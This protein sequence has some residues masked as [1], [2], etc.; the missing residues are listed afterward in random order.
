MPADERRHTPAAGSD[1]EES[2]YFDF[3]AVDGSAAGFAR[4]GL[5][6]A[7]GRAWWWTAVTGRDRPLVLVR[8]HDVDPPR[9]GSLEIRASGLWAE[10]VCETPLDHWSLGLE[11]LAVAL[12]DPSD[13]YTSE[14]GDPVPLGLDLEWEA[15]DGPVPWPVADSHEGRYG[16]ACEVHGEVLV[17]RERLAVAGFGAREHTWGRRDWSGAVTTWAAGRFEDGT[18]IG[19]G[20]HVEATVE[21]DGQGLVAGGHVLLPQG[22]TASLRPAAHAPVQVPMVARV[23]RALCRIE[24]EDGRRGWGWVERVQPASSTT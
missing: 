11:A 5:R 21:L 19:P 3:L 1:W 9:G 15:T 24:A 12:G 23:A 6:P 16:Q 14:R 10:P 22:L 2:W 7:D 8:D 17:G 20:P 18:S 4:L 13:A